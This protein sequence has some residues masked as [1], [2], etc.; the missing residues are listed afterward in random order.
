MTFE[1]IIANSC[2]PIA[3]VKRIIVTR[4]QGVMALVELLDVETGRYVKHHIGGIL[5]LSLGSTEE[6]NEVS[7]NIY[8]IIS[9]L[10]R[11]LVLKQENGVWR[12]NNYCRYNRV[13]LCRHPFVIYSQ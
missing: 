9:I 7:R 12:E 11:L 2:K 6:S 3:E 4:H 1:N 8:K 10:Y 5:S 13:T